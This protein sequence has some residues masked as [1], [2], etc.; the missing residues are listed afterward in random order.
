M[1][2]SKKYATWECH[3]SRS[4]RSNPM[5][6]IHISSKKETKNESTIKSTTR[7]DP[8]IKL[9]LLWVF[10]ILNIAYA[11]ILSLMDPTSPIRT[12]M[13]GTPLPAGGFVGRR[14]LNGNFDCHGYP[15]MDFE[16]QSKSLGK[17]RYW[18]IEHPGRCNWRTRSILCFF[19]NSGSCEHV[20]DHLVCLE[21]AQP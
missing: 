15:V 11:D 8:K 3:W 10:V 19:C 14:N 7:I 12:A 21:V 18:R 20:A 13:A 1:A 17:H 4:F 2:C 6:L 16:L 9:S 5:K